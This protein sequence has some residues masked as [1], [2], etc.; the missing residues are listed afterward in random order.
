[1]TFAK[2][3]WLIAAAVSV[4]RVSATFAEDAAPSVAA[5]EVAADIEAEM[6]SSY[7][8]IATD[9]GLKDA[10]LAAFK[11][12]IN[13]GNKKLEAWKDS[14]NGK[15]LVDLRKQLAAA[16]KANDAEKV[17]ALRDEIAPL[18]KEMAALRT[19]GVVLA[20]LTPVQQT[21][22]VRAG[23]YRRVSNSVEDAGITPEQAAQIKALTDPK[24]DEYLKAHPLDK[25][26]GMMSLIGAQS[27][28][29]KKV[30]AEILT[31]E[32]QE[33]LKSAKPP[34]TKPAKGE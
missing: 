8:Q 29:T 34:A 11:S 23:L 18:N 15:K 19:R 4:G 14:E 21:A 7:A 9:A 5:K 20:S 31:A 32:Q 3:T 30:K 2:W 17:K 16:S 24:A 28:I 12:Q 27:A 1:M 13:E 33:K 26:P 25:D 6:T 22:V 10:E